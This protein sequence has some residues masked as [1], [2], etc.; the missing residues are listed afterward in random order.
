MSS[1]PIVLFG[2]F[3][4]HNLGDLLLGHAAAL[5]AAP[6][7]CLYAGL[8]AA[9]LTAQGGFVV[10]PVNEILDGWRERF[11]AASPDLVHVGG[12]ILDTDAWEAAVMLLDAPA[13]AAVVARLDADPAGR[14][15]WAA[16]FLASDRPA[17]Y[18]MGRHAL[19]AGSRLE[20]RALGGVGLARRDAAFK[21]A[22][23]EALVAAD[24]VTV[25]DHRTRAALAAL[26]IEAALAPDPVTDLGPWLA[27]AIDGVPPLGRGYVACQCAASF[28]DDGSLDA[29]AGAL[30]GRGAPVV[31]FQA[32]AAPWHDDPAVYEGLM[33][34]LTVPASRLPSLHLREICAVIARA[35][36]CISSSLHALLVAGLF[37]VPRAGLERTAGEGAKLR[38]YAETWG[39]FEVFSP[40]EIGNF[41]RS[42]QRL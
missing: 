23:A 32:G 38:A 4:R 28:G 14:A 42:Q 25:R 29:L 12:E 18:V 31:L 10:E 34:R 19:P 33:G 2:A 13:A 35:D 6:R 37:G 26:G 15:A 1:I 41:F 24:S 7:P 39:G 40:N 9:D 16:G 5:A 22:V 3:D 17:P 8:R 11:G 21:T 20:F 27:R 36:L 30:N